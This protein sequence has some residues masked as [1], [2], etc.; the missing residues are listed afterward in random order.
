MWTRLFLISLCALAA[1]GVLAAENECLGCHGPFDKLA[2]DTAKYVAPSG[3]KVSPHRYV[4][5]D[6]KKEEDIPECT[7]CHKAHAP[8][9]PPAAG[10]VD[11][12]KVGVQWCYDAC[13]H[14]KN[15][16]SCKQCHP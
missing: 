10:S 12:T 7:N 8:D 1:A 16:T 14:E 15:F 5:H 4:P 6:S 2:A 9:A 13:H 11:L 3:E